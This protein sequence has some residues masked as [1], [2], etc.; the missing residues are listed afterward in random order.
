M[1]AAQGT[2]V[3]AGVPYINLPS[4]NQLAWWSANRGVWS[5]TGLTTPAQNGGT[6]AGWSDQG[7]SGYHVTQSTA[8]DRPLYA[9]AVA[10]LNGRPA[11]QFV[12]SDFLIKTG[13][14]GAIVGNLNTYTIYVVFQTTDTVSAAYMYSE[15]NNSTATQF[16][17]VRHNL[18]A[19]EGFHRSDASV[20]AN[21]TG[22]TTAANGKA[23]ILTLR[24][25]ASNSWAVRQD[26][27]QV[28]TAATAPGTTTIN[29]VAL[30]CLARNTNGQFFTG[31]I[32]QIALYSA[33][34][35]AT[36]EPVLAG[37]YGIQLP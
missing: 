23:H 2:T 9:T 32:G 12:S 7:P 33:D 27:V 25:I 35:F 31:Y 22:G 21:P 29:Q 16:A 20:S 8:G 13:L 5:D 3:N 1:L 10:A 19:V 18:Q 24:R 11:V 4:T 26:G 6:V 36:I 14:S 17:A 37:F 34:N 28:G 15:G 30:G